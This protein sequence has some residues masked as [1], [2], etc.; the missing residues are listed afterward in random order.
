MTSTS[1]CSKLGTN[2]MLPWAISNDS[3]FIFLLP[4]G[5]AQ[6]ASMGENIT[7]PP[8]TKVQFTGAVSYNQMDVTGY[9]LVAVAVGVY[10]ES[11]G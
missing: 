8:G 6:Y 2:T 9:P 4:N 5:D 1:L 3:S 11:P 7:V 10:V